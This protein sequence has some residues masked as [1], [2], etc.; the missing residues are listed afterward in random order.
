MTCHFNTAPTKS[1][2][3]KPRTA[4]TL[5]QTSISCL[6]LLSLFCSFLPY[7]GFQF[8]W[9]L[10]LSSENPFSSLS[11]SYLVQL[12]PSTTM[13]L[14]LLLSRDPWLRPLSNGRNNNN[15]KIL[16]SFL[17]TYVNLSLICLYNLHACM[18]SSCTLTN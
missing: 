7:L 13:H 12:L 9:L 1:G 3:N 18:L 2:T 14:L 5:T 4:H 17:I 15:I 6:D 16:T 10:L 11:I 8:Q